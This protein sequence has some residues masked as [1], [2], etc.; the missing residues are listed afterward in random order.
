MPVPPRIA[1]KLQA[2]QGYLL[3][4]MPDQALAE[5]NEIDDRSAAEFEWNLL[6]GEALRM[7]GDFR[8]AIVAFQRCQRLQAD[9]LDVLMGLAWC[10]KRTDQL[11]KSIEAMHQ[12]YLSH[13]QEAIVLYNLSCYYSLAGNKDQA[14]SWLG[15]ALR[16]RPDL[17]RLIADES[18][19]DPLREDADFQH[20]LDLSEPERRKA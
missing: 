1:R 4:E 19:F 15:R 10:Y 12:A 5:L 18:D 7:R 8:G 11:S 17:R 3:L 16:M 2:A 14:L 9:V 13:R 20:L 6:R